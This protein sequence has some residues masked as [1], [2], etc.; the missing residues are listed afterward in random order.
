MGSATVT[1]S[2]SLLQVDSLTECKEEGG[3]EDEE[4]SS[5]PHH[6]I[7]K[8]GPHMMLARPILPVD[9][10]INNNN[11]SEMRLR[12]SLPAAA[13][14]R[15]EWRRRRASLFDHLTAPPSAAASCRD[16]SP[17]ALATGHAIA[18]RGSHVPVL[19]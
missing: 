8:N 14:E 4:T 9:S 1:Q 12:V 6:H 17:F 11:G 5:H 15:Y 18:Y 13:W 2:P 16:A 7:T 10:S 3:D 19:Q